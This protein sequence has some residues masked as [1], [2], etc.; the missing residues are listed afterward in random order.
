LKKIE[1]TELEKVLLNHR[2]QALYKVS[3]STPCEC[4]C[5]NNISDMH[6]GQTLCPTYGKVHDTIFIS[7]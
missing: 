3:K 6:H 1:L 5:V 2:K 7:R 4:G